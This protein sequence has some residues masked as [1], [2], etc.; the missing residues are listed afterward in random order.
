M[1]YQEIENYEE[2]NPY[3]PIRHGW[4]TLFMLLLYWLLLG[5]C[6]TLVLYVTLENFYSHLAA[7]TEISRGAILFSTGSISILISLYFFVTKES[8][9]ILRFLECNITG[10]K[11]WCYLKKGQIQYLVTSRKTF[12]AKDKVPASI[13]VFPYLGVALGGWKHKHSL[14]FSLW[15]IKAAGVGQYGCKEYPSYLVRL[16]L[17]DIDSEVVTLNAETALRLIQRY[18]DATGGEPFYLRFEEALMQLD[19]RE[20]RT[21]SDL[22]HQKDLV[23]SLF[24]IMIKTT[25]DIKDSTRFGKSSEGKKIRLEL[26]DALLQLLPADDPNRAGLEEQ[27]MEDSKKIQNRKAS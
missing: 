9:I 14:P 18:Q 25:K 12:L 23:E 17:Q 10:Y 3:L 1:V 15:R 11:L 22:K 21:Q 20:A 27:L 5:A 6:G 13:E 24:Q 4:L 16:I 26:I 8:E 2:L 19:L 7:T